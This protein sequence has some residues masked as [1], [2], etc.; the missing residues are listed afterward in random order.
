MGICCYPEGGKTPSSLLQN[1]DIAMYHAKKNRYGRKW[2]YFNPKMKES[3]QREFL[4][5]QKLIT[6]YEKNEFY[7]EYQPQFCIKNP[8]SI[9]GIEALV[10]WKNEELGQINPDEFI[11]ILEANGYIRGLSDYVIR[12]VC[13][14]LR[15]CDIQALFVPRISIN[16]SALEIDETLPTRI[17]DT[18][19]SYGISGERIT[20]EITESVQ[21]YNSKDAIESIH[22]LQNKGVKIS[23]DDFG[24]G[25]SSLS[26]LGNIGADEVK[27]DREFIRNYHDK[28][29]GEI[30]EAVVALS[31]VYGFRVVAEGVENEEELT[32]LHSINCPCGQGFLVSKPLSKEDILKFLK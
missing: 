29:K 22:L 11:P 12:E 19:K 17:F 10:R 9:T 16:L 6:A 2:E 32:Y 3:S 4:I 23:L 26:Y 8:T 7:L 30:I 18:L 25:Y 15:E 13:G 21:L 24:T 20:L 31:N 27:I 1:A 28:T 5:E 14:L